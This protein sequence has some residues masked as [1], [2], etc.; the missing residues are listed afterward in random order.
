MR[1]SDVIVVSFLLLDCLEAAYST[2]G[3]SGYIFNGS[4]LLPDRFSCQNLVLEVADTAH[5]LHG[6]G[7]VHEP[8]YRS[9]L[10]QTPL[11]MSVSMQEPLYINLCT[12]ASVKEPLYSSLCT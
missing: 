8:L 5:S 6:G 4:Q 9:L 2:Q 12:M 7:S 11:Y 10:I 3:I 1:T